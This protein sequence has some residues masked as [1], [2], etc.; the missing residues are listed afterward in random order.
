MRDD[1][2]DKICKLHQNTTWCW[3]DTKDL[4]NVLLNSMQ[5]MRTLHSVCHG[6]CWVSITIRLTTETTA[7]IT[8]LQ[9]NGIIYICPPALNAKCWP[10]HFP[11]HSDWYR[12]SHRDWTVHPKRFTWGHLRPV[13]HKYWELCLGLGCEENLYLFCNCSSSHFPSWKF[14][15]SKWTL[16]PWALLGCK[17]HAKPRV[18]VHTRILNSL[19]V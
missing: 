12:I 7:D 2:L 18:S 14:S 15:T 5:G 6:L 13:T 19:G 4:E 17:L 11:W 8:D 3:E 16:N 1:Q 10:T 9:W